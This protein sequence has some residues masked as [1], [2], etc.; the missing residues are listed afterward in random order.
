[1][2]L[3]NLP[4]AQ[5]GKTNLLRRPLPSPHRPRRPQRFPLPQHES[6]PLVPPGPRH[7]SCDDDSHFRLLGCFTRRQEARSR[8]GRRDST[9]VTEPGKREGTRCEED[10]AKGG[11]R[12]EVWA[13]QTR[14]EGS[15]DGEGRDEVGGAVCAWVRRAGVGRAR[16]GECFLK[17]AP[18]ISRS[19]ASFL[20][21]LSFINFA[22][23]VQLIV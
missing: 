7:S 4:L 9:W 21:L 10:G 5:P 16:D 20:R 15:R 8:R 18:G 1:M 6:A 11:W 22:C 12:S 3:L 13:V 17:G 19:Y 14:W 2:V 23:Y